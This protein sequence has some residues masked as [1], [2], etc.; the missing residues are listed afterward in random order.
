MLGSRSRVSDDGRSGNAG[1]VDATEMLSTVAGASGLTCRQADDVLIATLT[2]VSEVVSAEE[3]RDLFGQ[4]PRSVRQRVPVRGQT[5][6]MGPTE[7]V[8]R[9]ADLTTTTN[10]EAERNVRVVLQV[11]TQAVNAG[12]L[13]RSVSVSKAA[14][15]LA[16]VAA[17]LTY[18]SVFAMFPA[19]I[20][21]VNVVRL[22][23]HAAKTTN[24]IVRIIDKLGPK[25]AVQTLR[26]G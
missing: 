16:D 25:S 6:S 23:G 4:L 26:R 9:V 18:Y 14:D 20:V 8:A 7:F 22:F 21:L 15:N 2:V 3:V 10:E 11:L 24:A 17:G 19:L 5:V 13:P 1:P 12:V